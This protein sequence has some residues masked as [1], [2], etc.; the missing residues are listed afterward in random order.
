VLA[1]IRL[2]V[3]L[4]MLALP[5]WVGGVLARPG[6]GLGS[7]ILRLPS[8]VVLLAGPLLVMAALKDGATAVGVLRTQAVALG[9]LVFLAGLG[10]LVGRVAGPRA[11][12]VLIA[13]VG[14]GVVGSVVWAGPIVALLEGPAQAMAAQVAVHGNPL[15]VAEQELGLVWLRQD[16]TYRISPFGESYSYLVPGVAWWKTLL[17]HLFI[18][19]GL[20]VFSLP[21]KGRNSDGVTK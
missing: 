10:V 21:R 20:L 13:L 1:M 18:G 14:W 9:F 15:V 19:S 11:A 2:V 3:A 5:V 17:A 7:R 16:L 4:E 8:A 6:A 12:Q